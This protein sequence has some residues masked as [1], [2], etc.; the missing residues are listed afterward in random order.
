M[1]T[2]I[3]W[4]YETTGSILP[5]FFLR[6]L[7]FCGLCHPRVSSS[8]TTIRPNSWKKSYVVAIL[9]ALLPL[10]NIG[11]WVFFYIK[12]IATLDFFVLARLVNNVS[13]LLQGP[14]FLLVYSDLGEPCSDCWNDLLEKTRYQLLS[15][16]VNS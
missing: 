15:D 13:Q 4:E 3:S 11:D 9:T 5:L 14:L 8:P 16:P 2:L 6:Y 10:L 7:R 12:E 1:P